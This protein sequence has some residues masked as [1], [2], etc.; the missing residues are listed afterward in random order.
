MNVKIGFD[1]ESSYALEQKLREL[2]FLFSTIAGTC[3]GDR[4]FG[5]DTDFLSYPME[6]AENLFVL[7]AEEKVEKYVPDME[8]QEIKFEYTEDGEMIPHITFI[9]KEDYEEEDIDV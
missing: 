3:V 1:Y 6:I 8:I 7:E 9:K 5:I 2:E 4:E